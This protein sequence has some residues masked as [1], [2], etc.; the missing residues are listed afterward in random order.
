MVSTEETLNGEAVYS[1]PYPRPAVTVDIILF[2]FQ[3][4]QLTTLLIQRKN[5]PFKG[6]GRCPAVS[7]TWTRI[8][9]MRHCV[10]WRKRPT[11]R[12]S[13]S[14]SS[15]PLA[16]RIRDPRA[17]VVTVAYFALAECRRSWRP[18]KCAAATT[19][20]THAGGTST[21]CP[22]WPST[23]IASSTMRCSGCA[24]NWSGPHWASCSCRPNSRCPNFRRSTK[25]CS[26]S[27]W[28]SATFAARC[29]HRDVL[30]ET[31]NLREGDHRPARLYRFGAGPSN[32][33]KR[34]VVSHKHRFGARPR[35]KQIRSV[36]HCSQQE[37]ES[38]RTLHP[39]FQPRPLVRQR[40]QAISLNV[41]SIAGRC[42]K[43]S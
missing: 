41:C 15:T 2:A 13:I 21:I 43:N 8:C 40:V 16:N 24:G 27:S 4:D 26:T 34:D 20:E 29:L 35:C 22:N 1:Y 33:N 17:R 3:N 28:T 19:P 32:W 5:E 14:N 6:N 38:K 36:R 12:T 18:R 23:T 30:E 25:S 9:T 37:I 10:S 39:G 31:G 11:S 7:S 42:R